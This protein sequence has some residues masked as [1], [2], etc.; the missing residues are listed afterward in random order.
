MPTVWENSFKVRNS[1]RQSAFALQLVQHTANVDS[2]SL[3]F[4]VLL[5][6]C[7][8]SFFAGFVHERHVIQIEYT[9]GLLAGAS[10][11]R[12]KIVFR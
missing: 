3:E 8:Q 4:H 5:C 10:C 1:L 6:E 12:P 9:C 11:V 7:P 2:A